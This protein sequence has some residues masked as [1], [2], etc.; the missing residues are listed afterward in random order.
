MKNNYKSFADLYTEIIKDISDKSGK[1]I[2]FVVNSLSE[3]EDAI[4]NE[5]ETTLNMDKS[6]YI[7]KF[8]GRLQ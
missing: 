7:K 2:D 4:K 8:I 1:S 3:V 6:Y 5:Y